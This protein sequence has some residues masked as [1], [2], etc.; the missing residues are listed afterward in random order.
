[1]GSTTA[2][3]IPKDPRE[4]RP[5]SCTAAS[6]QLL[7]PLRQL[8]MALTNERLQGFLPTFRV[9][10]QLLPPWAPRRGRAHRRATNIPWQVNVCGTSVRQSSS[11]RRGRRDETTTMRGNNNGNN[12]S[13]GGTTKGAYD[14][15]DDYTPRHECDGPVPA[16]AQCS[17]YILSS[18]LKS[19]LL[20]APTPP[21]PNKEGTSGRVL[22][23][24]PPLAHSRS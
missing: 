19:P 1:M 23:T 4:Q 12:N 18:Q 13:D 17:L 15:M 24:V 11:S 5:I 7:S 10:S 21:H 3:R 14:T 9:A 22:S 20:P 6:R 16:R 2:L 8:P